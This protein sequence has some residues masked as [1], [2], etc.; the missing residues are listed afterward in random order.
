[1]RPYGNSA[2]IYYS[3]LVTRYSSLLSG[4]TNGAESIPF[5]LRNSYL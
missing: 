5:Q 4:P 3:L 1:M 2:M